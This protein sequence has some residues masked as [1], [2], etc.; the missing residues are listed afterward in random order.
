MD[1]GSSTNPFGSDVPP[2][3]YGAPTPPPP[4]PGYG[5]PM[6]PPPGYGAPQTPPGWAPPGYGAPGGYGTGVPSS[7]ARTWAMLSHLSI[8]VIGIIGPLVIMLT[9]GKEDTFVR[10][11]AVEALNFQIT[12]FIA[13]IVSFI[14]FFIVIGIFTFLATVIAGIVLAI[15]ASIAAYRGEHYRYPVTL[16][17]VK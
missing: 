8:F 10:E 14:L 1:E 16:R 3:G 15:M 6:P 13:Y 9:K 12:L 11:Q 2:A 7:D 5:A 17:M 4:P